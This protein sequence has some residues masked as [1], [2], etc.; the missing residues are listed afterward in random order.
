MTKIVDLVTAWSRFEE[1]HP[2]GTVE[3]FCTY[4]L[5]RK[6]KKVNKK[7]VLQT[8]EPA[9][10]RFAL[11]KAM[12]RISKIWV[13]HA[14][15]AL[16]PLDINSFDEFIF[17]LLIEGDQ[18][19]RKTE[20]I[21]SQFFELSSGLLIIDRLIKK[22]FVKE[23]EDPQDKRSKLL[24]T[25]KLGKEK[26]LKGRTAIGDVA[27]QLFDD[28]PEDDIALCAQLLSPLEKHAAQQWH[29]LKFES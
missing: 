23:A 12:N 19:L 28:M 10:V 29:Q 18:P 25:T 14:Q 15:A 20:V 6:K 27:G 4:H 26:L 11:T 3:E 9:D 1:K 22:G 13:A 2:D 16:K 7:S 17:L 21:Y 24:S 5:T 8:N